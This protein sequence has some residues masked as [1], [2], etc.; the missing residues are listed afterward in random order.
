MWVDLAKSWRNQGMLDAAADALD[1]A[2]ELLKP[3]PEPVLEARIRVERGDLHRER[4]HF[5][6][7]FTDLMA[8][9]E[10]TQQ[11]G[12]LHG[13]AL[14]INNLAVMRDVQGEL[15][16]ACDGY[17][18]A[19]RLFAED[20]CQGCRPGTAQPWSLLFEAWLFARSPAALFGALQAVEQLPQ[21][22]G[23][24]PRSYARSAGGIVLRASR[25]R[26]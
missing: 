17:Q 21:A 5:E 11:A 9:A 8:A 3:L 25:S 10:V 18:R 20:Q 19:H 6:E 15:A 23:L 1:K 4:G 26:L 7:A 24:R 22:S 12:D 14:A 2:I 13:L 16:V